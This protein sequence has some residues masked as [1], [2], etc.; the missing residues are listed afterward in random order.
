MPKMKMLSIQ[1]SKISPIKEMEDLIRSA[2][3]HVKPSF[4]YPDP[5]GLDKLKNQVKL[6]HPHWSGDVLMTNSATEA[7]YLALSEIRGGCLAL[8]VPSY[9]GILR[10]AKELGI[11]IIEWRTMDDLRKIDNFD[12]ILFTSNF[13]PPTGKSFSD[14][15]KSEIAVMANNKSAIV[16]EDN[17]YELLGYND[18]PLSAISA[19]KS[20]KIGSFSKML[21]PSLRMGYLVSSGVLFKNIRSRKITMNLSSS[22]LSQSIISKILE[23]ENIIKLWREELLHRALIMQDDLSFIFFTAVPIYDGGCFLKFPLR[24]DINLEDLKK[25]TESNGLLID[26][27]NGQYLDN[28]SRPYLRIN[29]AAIQK[30]DIND[31]VIILKNAIDH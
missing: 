23:D 21:T 10:Q 14:S 4:D 1:S 2:V 19:Y 8:N 29:L 3:K 15:E 30:E 20:I 5:S 22:E 12:A 6:L 25:E 28:K 9:F 27:N 7:T 24:D 18:K 16:I 31:A 26:C 11:K 13:T 17:A